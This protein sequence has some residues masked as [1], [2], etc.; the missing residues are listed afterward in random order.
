MLSPTPARLAQHPGGAGA[1][2]T[3]SSAHDTD[4]VA[5]LVDL[6]SAGRAYP[7]PGRDPAPPLPGGH[8]REA[9]LAPDTG[10]TARFDLRA[11]SNA[12]LA[13]HRIRLEIASSDFLQF[14]RNLGTG[15]RGR[16]KAT[17]IVAENAV[18]HSARYPPSG[19]SAPH[20]LAVHESPAPDICAVTRRT[21]RASPEEPQA[22]SRWSCRACHRVLWGRRRVEGEHRLAATA[23]RGRSLPLQKMPREAPGCCAPPSG[24][25]FVPGSTS[26]RVLCTSERD[27]VWVSTRYRVE[28][29]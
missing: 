20:D 6:Y 11:T 19:R 25:V 8:D 9:W 14:D 28:G 1:G 13:G 26:P 12:F 15:G 27:W 5:T 4:S 3:L 7:V 22:A 2:W 24:R 21:E 10:V 29:R 18:P 16:D 17:W 23:A